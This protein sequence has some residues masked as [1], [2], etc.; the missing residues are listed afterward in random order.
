VESNRETYTPVPVRIGTAEEFARVADAL[1][2]ARFDEKTLCRVFKLE[3]ISDIASANL[4]SLD[5]ADASEAFL[6]YSRLFVL[7]DHISRA[8]A[9][10]IAGPATLEAFL[11]LGLIRLG[12]F[13]GVEEF[14]TPVF[15]YP[16]A[17]SWIASDRRDNIDGAPEP[18]QPDLVFPAIFSG[19]LNFLRLISKSPAQDVLD[20]C[21]GSGIGAIVL[22]RRARHVV[23][24]DLTNRAARYADFNRQL[25][26]CNN[27]EIAVGDLYDSVRGRTFDRIT[28][29]PPYMPDLG[30]SVTWRDAGQ[31]GETLIQR[32]VRGLPEFLRPA[33]TFYTVCV[34][35]DTREGPFEERVRR[36]FADAEGEFDILFGILEE[37][38]PKDYVADLFGGRGDPSVVA[39][40]EQMYARAGVGQIVYGALVIHR[41]EGATGAPWT[42]RRRI[43]AATEGADLEKAMYWNSQGRQEAG[44]RRMALSKPRLAPDLEMQVIHIV[45]D[46]V[47][48]PGDVLLETA[49]PFAQ[50]LRI[51][52]RIALLLAEFNGER[53]VE[54]VHGSAHSGADTPGAPSLDDFAG[55][56]ARLTGRGILIPGESSR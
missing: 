35:L 40:L 49:R 13:A 54:E 1:R 45:V 10:R 42:E 56:V 9:E 22:S 26:Q 39:R 28:A 36:W 17:E 33:G 20:L 29:H 48:A 24:S 14:Y 44:R 31:T 4:E 12:T 46:G 27:V 5:R 52:P 15:F 30:E 2:A 21:G 38:A 19:T 6:L 50:A 7:L 53:T 55:L 16:V 23:S 8:D 11:S 51:D 41:R 18:S 32:I 3:D 25:N 34:G 37:H 47:L 43:T